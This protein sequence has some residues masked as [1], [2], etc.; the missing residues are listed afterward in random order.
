MKRF[1]KILAIVATVVIALMVVLVVLAK[2][3]ITPERVK[4]TVLP[5]VEENLQR[6]V[7]LGDIEVSIFSGIGL[8]DLK[9]YDKDG[10]EV[11]VST[12]RVQLDYQL[13]PL[14]GLKVV[15]DNV[16][17]EQ[18]KIRIVRAADGRFNFA[19]LLGKTEASSAV[20]EP[21]SA[22]DTGGAT[23]ISLL[24]SQARITGGEV[25]F[26]DH[27]INPQAPYRTVVSDLRVAVEGLTLTG[28]VPVK[29]A[30][31]IND[32][33]FSA[34]GEVDLTG[35][36][37]QFTITMQGVDMVA[38]RPYFSDALPGQLEGLSLNLETRLTGGRDKISAAGTLVGDNLDLT[39]DALPDA[40]ISDSR[41]QLDYDLAFDLASGNLALQNARV[42]FNGVVA[43]ASGILQ[44]LFAKPVVD[45]HVLAPEIELRAAMDGLPESLVAA[46]TGYDLSGRVSLD[47]SL[48]G[49]V[50]APL[51]LLQQ[52]TVALDNVHASVGG[53]RPALTGKL[54][55][56]SDRVVS[57]GLIVDL[58]DNRA[59]IALEAR[60]IFSQPVIVQADV[61]AET[62][63]LDPILGAGGAAAGAA[64][65]TPSNAEGKSAEEI[66]PMDIPVRAEGTI[67]IGQT[68]YQGVEINNFVAQYALKDNLLTVS[69]MDGQVA[70]GSFNNSARVDLRTRGL[71]YTLDLNIKAIQADSVLKAFLPKA[72]DTLFGAMNLDMT[73]KGRGTQWPALRQQ[74]TGQ[75]EVQV[76]NG[77]IVSPA[78]VNGLTS[79]LQLTSAN[80]IK[81]KT[82][83]GNLRI[84]DGKIQVD[85]RM[86]SDQIKL[87]PKG[88]IGLDGQ[89]DLA[90]DTR[91]S[92]QLSG[93]LDSGGKVT[94]YLT[95]QEGWSQLPLLV[96]GDVTAP[97]FGL[98]P[99]GLQ[100]KATEV[101]GKEL[102]EQLD[103][104]L[105]GRQESPADASQQDGQ[106]TAPTES[107]GE[108][109]LQDSLKK[110]F[111]N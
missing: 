53:L 42:D 64:D 14:L 86:T 82:L 17:V 13:L 19:D 77:R 32:G 6:K 90:M 34:D 28:R 71:A 87:F 69:R 37:G 40:P 44:S 2:V 95:D 5:I 48:S 30:C 12:Q 10:S 79:F 101:I 84:K 38:F 105:G 3:V 46:Y 52:A 55:L 33:H 41:I 68:L 103:K 98:D 80:E 27:L 35:P 99:K 21:D 25:V 7:E 75:G 108:K 18:P 85:S 100:K 16:L 15:I 111:G 31:Q 92:P 81:F 88:T 47:A 29:V 91:L 62:F 78:L 66:G 39:L 63:L 107:S 20:P 102:G 22:S 72:A 67:T 74:L 11:F 51:K 57:E 49:G 61:T 70:G 1:A 94:R 96:T 109:L 89:L 106:Q 8:N 73:V 58:G 76:E 26:L 24:V 23:P 4:Q 83:Q 104:L 36:T 65:Q 43:E 56:E 93:Q 110:L 45:L 50:A 59:D 60:N 9:V 97:R 54:K